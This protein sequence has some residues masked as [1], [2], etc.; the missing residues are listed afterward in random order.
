MNALPI[1]D[2]EPSESH[3]DEAFA[4][5]VQ[6]DDLLN[7]FMLETDV[8]IAAVYQ[9]FHRHGGLPSSNG[10][11]RDDA[12]IES[13]QI[14]MDNFFDH[15]RQW[16]GERLTVKAQ[17]VMDAEIQA[18]KDEAAEARHEDREYERNFG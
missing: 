14:T 6:D 11:E 8:T 15:Y 9:L 16:L 2:P 12:M 13:W 1:Y 5:L 17:Q 10:T 7:A 18:A 3:F 4:E